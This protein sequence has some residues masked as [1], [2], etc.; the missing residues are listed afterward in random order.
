MSIQEDQKDYWKKKYNQHQLNL[1]SLGSE[2]EAHKLLRYSKISQIFENQTEF[3]LLDVG[4]GF[5]DYYHYLKLFN[6]NLMINYK[7]VEITEEF[8][9]IGKQKY[10]QI[11][12]SNL[13]ILTEHIDEYDFVILS[14]IFHQNGTTENNEW[15]EF[16]YNLISKA[17]EISTKGIAFNV[18]SD[19]VEFKRDGNFYP[20][21]FELQKFIRDKLSRFTIV[22]SN[23][24]LFESTYFVYKKDFIKNN[25]PQE[26]LSKYLK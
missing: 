17:F 5:G 11:N 25:Y 7:G 10:P 18:L 6:P 16:M 1:K 22:D 24:P 15:T 2:T 8:V 20:D 4:C 19:F 13:N 23:Y 3:S 9:E 12:I 26:E 14:G 21:A